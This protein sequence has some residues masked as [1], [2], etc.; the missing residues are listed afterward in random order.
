MDKVAA[1]LQ[2]AVR[3]GG[4]LFLTIRIWRV[5]MPHFP[6]KQLLRDPPCGIILKE[7]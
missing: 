7:I 3:K 2:G 1:A 4:F 5:F 6:H